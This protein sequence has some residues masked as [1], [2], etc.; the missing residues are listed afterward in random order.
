M[1]PDNFIFVY[2][3]IAL[4]KIHKF[5]FYISTNSFTCLLEEMP[6]IEKKMSLAYAR[7]KCLHHSFEYSYKSTPFSGVFTYEALNN[8]MTTLQKF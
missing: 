7:Y 1:S 8:D 3:A 5:I 2:F 6:A 4:K